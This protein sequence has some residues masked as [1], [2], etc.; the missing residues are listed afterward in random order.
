MRRNW[1]IITL[2]LVG[3]LIVSSIAFAQEGNTTTY[4]VQRGDTL[5]RIA[6]RNQTTI[7]E[8]MRI[9][10]DIT[11]PNLVY[12]GQTINIPAPGAPAGEVIPTPLPIPETAIQLI[13]TTPITTLEYGIEVNLIGH[14]DAT[15][16]LNALGMNWVKQEINWRDFEPVKGQI[17]YAALDAIVAMLEGQSTKILFTITSAPDWS[18]SIQEENGPPDNF[19]DFG[20]FVTAL[21]ARYAGRVN[22]YE[23]WNEPNLRSKWK[24]TVHSISPESYLQLLRFGYDAVKAANPDAIVVTAGLAPTGYNDAFNAAV[25]NLEVNAIDDRVFLTGLYAAG[26]ANYADAIGAHPIGWANPP[27][28]V[29]CT[30][31]EGVTTHFESPTFYFLNTL[32]DYRQIMEQNGD[33]A[34]P[35]WVTKFGWG[36]SEDLGAPDETNVYVGY[37]S[38]AEQA[39]YTTRAFEI[40]AALGYV[41]PMFVY[42]L[43]GCQ[44]MDTFGA[45]GCYYS[46]L[47]PD[48]NPRPAYVS[49]QAIDKTIVIPTP[50]PE[51]TV[52]ATAEATAEATSE[53]TQEATAEATQEATPEATI[54]ATTEATAEPT[55]EV[56]PEVTVESGG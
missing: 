1:L 53:A 55:I 9:N 4:V 51:T 10:P 26:V 25:G 29:C 56:T 15:A 38:L 20:N 36:T 2:L 41:G 19:A 52:E 32:Q 47:G 14:E 33:S 37:T 22:A 48:A 30:A 31:P 50:E 54:E 11:N 17:D 3:L 18:R 45:D 12:F 44:A 42:N 8:L 6:V 23:I 28:A 40:G 13:T 43:N 7:S 5:Y 39:Q 21:S 46:L 24:S 27:D 49:V 16:S 35:I 34:T